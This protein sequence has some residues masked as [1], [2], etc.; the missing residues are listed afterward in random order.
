V[1]L[2]RREFLKKGGLLAA[3]LAVP[4][5]Q[6]ATRPAPVGRPFF[7][8]NSLARFVDPLPIPPPARPVGHRPSPT[9]PGRQIPYYRIEMRQ[10]ETKLHRDLKPAR[11]WG[12]NSSVPGPT[13]EARKGEGFLVE[14]INALPREHFLPIDHNLH[15][16]EANLPQVRTV[17]HVHGAKAPP[18]SDGYPEDWFVSGKSTVSYYSNDQDAAALWYHDHAM[19]INR[20]NIYAGLLGSFL[21]RDEVESHLDLPSGQYEI[22]LIVYDRVLDK[23]GQLHYP[24]SGN[25][26]APW[27]P[28]LYGNTILVNGKVCPYLEVQPRQYRIRL[29]NGANTRFFLFSLSNRAPFYQIGT[30]LGLLPVPVPLT[31]LLLY[32]AERADL[33]IDFA[34]LEGKSITLKSASVDL[35]QFRVTQPGSKDWK[36]L[37]AK[38]AEVP[39]LSESEAVKTR[40]LTLMD[41]YDYAGNS[42]RMLLN[43]THW[44]APITE[45]PVINTV[46]IWSLINL[47]DDAHPIHL[48]LVRFQILDRR[49]FDEFAYN[50]SKTLKYVGPALPPDPNEA[51]WKDTVRVDPGTVTRIIARFEGYTGRYVWHCHLLEHEDNEMM[52]P[53]EVVA[54]T[55]EQAVLPSDVEL[56][57]EWCVDGRASGN[58]Y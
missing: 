54:T 23:N 58:P 55:A 48:H 3:A 46:E 24:V 47:T 44:K 57:A 7:N 41:Y 50:T 25:P 43:G 39:K 40:V 28:E 14:W 18:A 2:S 19:G 37:P 42:M 56:T 10:F 15:G 31:N 33:I 4:N 5:S 17:V 53:Y 36:Q 11:Q 27:I 49:R 8:P 1:P 38:L 32:P 12:F 13:F 45:K 21:I 22:P 20:L 51:G 52:R 29:L 9:D 30:D 26:N 6:S 34:G 35:M 16:A